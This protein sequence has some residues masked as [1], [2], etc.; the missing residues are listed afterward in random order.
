MDLYQ[1]LSALSIQTDN[2]AIFW[3]VAGLSVFSVA[4]SKSGF[5][6]AM[7]ALAALLM[8]TVLLP[9]RPAV[10]PVFG[11]RFLDGLYLARL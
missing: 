9:N 2:M 11:D 7:G 5:G 6:G 3:F 4:V 8:L 10:A 1:R